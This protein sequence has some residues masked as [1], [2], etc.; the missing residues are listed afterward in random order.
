MDPLLQQLLEW[1]P[2]K[3]KLVIKHFPL[4]SHKFA[5]KAA[6]AS[7]AAG[8]QGKFWQFHRKLFK[9]YQSLNDAKIKN[10]AHG[11]KLDMK[12]F[13]SD[14]KSPALDDMIKKDQANGY[15]IGVRGTPAIFING[16]AVKRRNP[17]SIRRMIEE[18]LK[19]N[20]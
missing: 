13:S 14:L 10:I 1:Y 19:K 5:K 20:K 4:R 8:K 6:M 11:L 7:L 17:Q 16:K 18:E 9:N 2:G 12:K 3:V 15:R